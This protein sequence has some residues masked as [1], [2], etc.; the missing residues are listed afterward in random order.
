M[1]RFR[2]YAS[3]SPVISSSYIGSVGSM[4]V[5]LT[6]SRVRTSIPSLAKDNHPHH[7]CP[8]SHSTGGSAVAY[9]QNGAMLGR[10]LY[11]ASCAMS[12]RVI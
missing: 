1:S 7:G 3:V 12:Y 5:G 11:S 2:F 4:M 8:F 10:F 9:C 6:R